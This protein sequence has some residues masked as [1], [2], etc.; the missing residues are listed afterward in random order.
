MLIDIVILPP[1]KIRKMIGK[2]IKKEIGGFPNFF[3]V[4]NIK[5]FPHLSLWHMKISRRGINN[6]AKKLKQIAKWQKQIKISSLGFH[7]LEK[8]KGCLEFTVKENK[9]LIQLQHKV[10]QNIY[11]Y[12]SGVMPQFASFL[13]I[14]YSREKLREIKKYGRALGFEP[15]L[16]MGWLKNEKDV[17]EV[18]KKMREMKFSFSAKEIYICEINKWW[19]VKK[20]IRKISFYVFQKNL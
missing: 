12:K 3:V 1:Q 9:D 6:I 19:Q 5:L 18:V 14:T 8:Y 15:H 13:G 11:S 7:A 17:E 16:T 2:K 20:I 10:F 4:D